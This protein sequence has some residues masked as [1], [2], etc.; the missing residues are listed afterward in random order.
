MKTNCFM[1]PFGLLFIIGISMSCSFPRVLPVRVGNMTVEDAFPNQRVRGLIQAAL[2]HD[3]TEVD[4]QLRAGADPNTIGKGGILPIHWLMQA[5]DV[6]ALEY[7]LLRGMNP[8]QPDGDGC[9]AVV[10]AARRHP[11]RI[12]EVLLRHKG[13]PNGKDE[14]GKPALFHAI[15]GRRTREGGGSLNGSNIE[16]LLKYGADINADTGS[17]PGR[18][19][20]ENLAESPAATADFEVVD[21]LLDHGLKRNLEGLAEVLG[22]RLYADRGRAKADKI[23]D[24][25]RAMGVR[26]PPPYKRIVP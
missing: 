3:F 5:E 17:M 23:L 10:W 8:N 15:R 12:L 19:E 7:L 6:M 18:P 4:A 16:I 24:R 11:S 22:N 1:L 25:L 20:G 14:N 21:Y 13:D 2:R 26:I 9:P